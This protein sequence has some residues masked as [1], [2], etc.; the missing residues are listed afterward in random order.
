MVL[1]EYTTWLIMQCTFSISR[2]CTMQDITVPGHQSTRTPLH[3]DMIAPG[4]RT[5]LY[6]IPAHYTIPGHQ[7]TRIPLPLYQDITIPGHQS[8]RTRTTTP[9]HHC[10]RTPLHQDIQ[11]AGHLYTRAQQYQDTGIHLPLYTYTRTPHTPA[12]APGHHRKR[13]PHTTLPGHH[14]TRTPHYQDTTLPVHHYTRTPHYQEIMVSGHHCTGTEDT[15]YQDTKT[16]TSCTIP[17]HHHIR[18]SPSMASPYQDKTIPGHH[19][20]P[21]NFHTR[22][23]PYQL[24]HHHI[25]EQDTTILEISVFQCIP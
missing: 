8:T 25:K 21:G 9:E 13:T 20:I 7:S 4:C 3:Q 5:P 1:W 19:I 17:R 24:G 22:T 11:G 6:Q 10:T 23:P 2:H 15:Q 14:C 18:T 12:S 16:R